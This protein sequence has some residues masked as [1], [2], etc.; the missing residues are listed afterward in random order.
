MY[1]P[2]DENSFPGT[3]AKSSLRAAN[4]SVPVVFFSRSTM[5]VMK[6]DVPFLAVFGLFSCPSNWE[7]KFVVWYAGF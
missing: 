4:S 3:N 7:R 5:Y 2:L 6:K 1:N